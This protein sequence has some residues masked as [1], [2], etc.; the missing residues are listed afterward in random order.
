MN[1]TAMAHQDAVERGRS[2]LAILACALAHFEEGLSARASAE[3]LQVALV[4]VKRMR[5]TLR[6]GRWDGAL[7]VTRRH[8]T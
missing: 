8:S 2:Q 1:V 3:R 4:T 6:L 7:V 5:A